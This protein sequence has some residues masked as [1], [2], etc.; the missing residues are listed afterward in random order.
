MSC[1]TG[2]AGRQTG[3]KTTLAAWSYALLSSAAT[4]HSVE[5]ASAQEITLQDIVIVE[6]RRVD[7]SIVD[8]PANVSAIDVNDLTESGPDAASNLARRVPNYNVVDT[9][10]PRAN[11]A[12][13]RGVGNLTFP[14][15]PFDTTIGYSVDGQPVSLFG[16]YSQ[17]LDVERVEVIRGPQNTL[18]GRGAQGGHINYV[19][20][21]PDG[22]R[23]I[24]L[25]G[26]V[27]TD[28]TY[29]SDILLGGKISENVA[30]RLA[31]RAAG[32][33]GFVRADLIGENLGESE[34]L[35]GRG[36]LKFQISPKTTLTA[37]GSIETDDRNSARFILRNSANFPASGLDQEP[38][39]D[40]DF[41]RGSLELKH[42][43]DAFDFTATATIQDIEARSRLDTVDGLIYGAFL[44]FVPANIPGTNFNG[45]DQ[46]ERA[47]SGE[48]R[49][50]SKKGAKVRWIA[51]A[52]I[53]SSTL[54]QINTD[55]SALLPFINGLSDTE[56]SL[57]TTSVFGEVGVPV[58]SKLTI[59]P[60]LRVGRDEF[61]FRNVYDSQ[62]AFVLVP[63]FSESDSRS[64]SWWA[65]GISVDYAF[66]KDGLVYGSVKRGHS[67]GGFPLINGNASSGIPQVTYPESVSLSYEAGAKANLFGG[68][69]YLSGAVFYN[70]VKD[71]HLF[72][73]DFVTGQ[74]IIAPQDYE[75]RGFEL[76]ARVKLDEATTVYGGV[77]VTK[78]NLIVTGA[79][80]A[81]AKPGGRVPGVANVMFNLG[82]ERE[83]NLAKLNLPGKLLTSADLQSVDDR[84]ADIANSFDLDSYTIVNAKVGWQGEN[85]KVYGFGRNLTDELPELSGTT[86]APGVEAVIVGRGR[87]FGVGAE[88]KF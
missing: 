33:D 20:R 40:R 81:G 76:E 28:G 5:P 14:L 64:E 35:A 82:I 11:F 65:G 22:K 36:S 12:S 62:G 6:A 53:Y 88:V 85:I 24:R 46:D 63:N 10:W 34:I 57:T 30:G 72:D 29:L 3:L 45:Y 56:L 78:T 59:T 70:D 87:V 73:F 37:S 80:T 71:G 41:A 67:A 21:E 51:G 84:A 2:T 54:Q 74:F 18:F 52:S 9:D 79:N 55:V 86:F 75:T 32:Q 48:A 47:Y 50:T 7:E 17:L 69:A 15:N 26:E 4:I 27:G 16:A 31:L 13:I 58:S 8:V 38:V 66:M 25:S 61:D 83:W 49:I 1:V 43:F 77:G 23:D 60:S 68:R 44:P 42:Q 19:T 39:N